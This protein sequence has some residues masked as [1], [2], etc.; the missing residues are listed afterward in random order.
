MKA[1]RLYWIF[2]TA[3]IRGGGEGRAR[4]ARDHGIYA[5]VGNKVSIQS[6]FIPVYSEL[7][8]FGNNVVVARNVDFVTHDITYAVLNR[9]PQEERQLFK[10]KERIGCIDICDNVF[11]GSNSIILYDTRIGPNVIIGSGSVVT[12]DCEPNSVYAGV[13]ARRIGS[14][15]DFVK[16]RAKQ[17]TSFEA[18]TTTHNQQL[19]EEEIS[20][21]W[22]RFRTSHVNAKEG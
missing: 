4:Y 18:S 6:R 22:N 16:R 13:P 2:R 21:A 19:T 12:K 3:L 8:S 14:F 5:H 10:F 9:L 11:I 15:E 20:A 17:E 7:I 1:K